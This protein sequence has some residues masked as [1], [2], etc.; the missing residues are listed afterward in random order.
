MTKESLPGK[1]ERIRFHT[2]D[3]MNHVS[4]T[5]V[6]GWYL[7]DD[8]AYTTVKGDNGYLYLVRENEIEF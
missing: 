8:E 5:V 6:E 2:P 4:G 7:D 3:K 1:G